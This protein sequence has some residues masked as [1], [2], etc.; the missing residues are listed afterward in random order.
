MQ[1]FLEI[2]RNSDDQ[3]RSVS[4]IVDFTTDNNFAVEPTSVEHLSESPLT[5]HH[6]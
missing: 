1:Q 5:E 4:I 2:A 3:N 6:A